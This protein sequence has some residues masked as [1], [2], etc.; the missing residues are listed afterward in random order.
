MNWFDATAGLQP[1]MDLTIGHDVGGQHRNRVGE[2]HGER[3]W[4]RP[5]TGP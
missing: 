2:Q 5:I 3:D 1:D 4:R